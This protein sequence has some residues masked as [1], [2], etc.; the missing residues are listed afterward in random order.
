MVDRVRRDKYAAVVIDMSASMVGMGEALRAIHEWK[1]KSGI[2]MPIIGVTNR[3]DRC[4]AGEQTD[5][6]IDELITITDS[7]ERLYQRI[8]ELPRPG[9]DLV[10]NDQT[11]PADPAR[12]LDR[13]KALA[14]ADGDIGLLMSVLDTIID[15]N[16][17]FLAATEQAV[18]VQDWKTISDGA[19]NLSR[20]ACGIGADII[21]GDTSEL[22]RLADAGDAAGISIII[23]RLKLNLQELSDE[24][25]TFE[26]EIAV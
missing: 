19:R 26:K 20:L 25:N 17:T 13:N 9:A 5:I 22:A 16:A 23:E 24:I 4:R 3:G 21:V 2:N 11:T 12:A 18:S 14:I 7:Y 8:N 1:Y 10:G 6:E 15:E